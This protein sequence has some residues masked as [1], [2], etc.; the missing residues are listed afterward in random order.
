MSNSQA[1]MFEEST[2]AEPLTVIQSFLDDEKFW[3]GARFR[4]LLCDGE[5]TVIPWEA[6]ITS[7][8]A[9]RYT[10]SGEVQFDDRPA[11]SVRAF[12]ELWQESKVG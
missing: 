4:G 6:D 3:K 10:L 11:V 7:E 9:S 8:D 5:G 12:F 1:A 2:T